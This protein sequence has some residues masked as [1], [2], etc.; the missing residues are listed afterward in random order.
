MIFS[1]EGNF[2]CEASFNNDPCDEESS[3]GSMSDLS[4]DEAMDIIYNKKEP[5]NLHK[6]LREMIDFKGNEYSHKP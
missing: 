1:Y 2:I 6:K 5:L 3:E 4:V